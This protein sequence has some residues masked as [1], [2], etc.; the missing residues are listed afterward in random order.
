MVWPDAQ[1]LTRLRASTPGDRGA[2]KKREQLSPQA[3]SVQPGYRLAAL[4]EIHM[5][6][7]TLLIIL[8]IIVVL[9]GG[10]YGRGRWF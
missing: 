2:E 4:K 3:Q 1:P 10:F 9:G 5:D 8:L 6:L 7:T